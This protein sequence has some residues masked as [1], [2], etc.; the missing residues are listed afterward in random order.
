MVHEAQIVDVNLVNWTV[1]V[2]TK[3]DQKKYLNIQVGSPYAHYNRGEGMYVVP[4]IGA[5][6]QVCIPSDGPPPFVLCF[7]MPMETI[8]GASEDAPDG[9]DGGKGDVTQESTGASFAGGRKRGKPG[10]IGITN[11]DG[12]F[13][14]MHRG[15]VVQIGATSLAQRLYIPLQNLV[16]DIS[17]NYQHL[18]TGGS[19]NWFV[20]QGE[21]STNPPTVSRHTYQ[22]LANDAKATVRVAIG[23]VTDVFTEPDERT[24]SDIEVAHE[25]DE[26]IVMEVVV[27]PDAIDSKSGAY[28]TETRKESVLRYYFDKTGNVL[29]RT[30]A[31]VVFHAKGRLRARVDG[32]VQLVSEGGMHLEF[33]G[34]G[35]LQV[36]G[37]LDIS[38]P[39]TRLNAGTKPVATVGSIVTVTVA[40]PVP[41]TVLV[42]GV[43]S[44]G[45][46]LAG[47]Q[48]MGI[49]MSGN[50]TVL[51]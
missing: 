48:M 2:I 35:R 34:A 3:F 51:A 49:V 12:S 9:T 33:E 24:R 11:R 22:L 1:D 6:C 27:A 17:Q 5:K 25:G 36:G 19:I 7:I 28:R 42:A 32:D 21:S 20:A 4:D 10:D 39:V 41:V 46:I 50:P 14:R 26:P 38:A 47:A 31:S 45:T 29:F 16:A 15:G 13:F 8:D 43:P 23:K 30:E 44:P 40:A 18:N 37:G